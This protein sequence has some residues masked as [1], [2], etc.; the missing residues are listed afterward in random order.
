[1]G[2]GSTAPGLLSVDFSVATLLYTK[3]IGLQLSLNKNPAHEIS[4]SWQTRR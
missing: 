2:P 1:M 3:G 4:A